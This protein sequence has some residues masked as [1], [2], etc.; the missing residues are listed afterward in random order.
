MRD[1]QTREEGN[2]SSEGVNGESSTVGALRLRGA[3]RSGPRVVW[4]EDVVDNEN[5]GKKSS[6][7]EHF[8]SS[9][10]T[11]YVWGAR[12]MGLRLV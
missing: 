6:K 7:S 9:Y 11:F 5:A 12:L 3:H 8:I 10:S 2:T 4:S 1:N